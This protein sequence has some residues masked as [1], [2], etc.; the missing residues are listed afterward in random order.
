MAQILVT[1]CGSPNNEYERRVI[2]DSDA[3]VFRER[4]DGGTT[5]IIAGEVFYLKEDLKEISM[6]INMAS[7]EAI[8]EMINSVLQS[9]AEVIKQIDIMSKRL[10]E[11]QLKLKR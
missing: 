2:I 1:V 11:M 6:L 7:L 4:P 9:Q 8:R 3:C 10:D 5:A